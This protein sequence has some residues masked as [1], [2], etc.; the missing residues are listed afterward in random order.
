MLTY[1]DTVTSQDGWVYNYTNYFRYSIYIGRMIPADSRYD[2]KVHLPEYTSIPVPQYTSIPVFWFACIPVYTPEETA[3]V[4]TGGGEEPRPVFC[5]KLV[6]D[7]NKKK[8]EDKNIT[9]NFGTRVD[10]NSNF[11]QYEL[12]EV[13]P[14]MLWS[15]YHGFRGKLKNIYGLGE[16]K[17]FWTKKDKQ[18]DLRNIINKWLNF[19][20]LW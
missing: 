14:L 8:D 19:K 12:W 11:Y 20:I 1:M 13:Y 2:E 4:G 15:V 5:W 3:Q 9:H 18:V 16:S 17:C 7:N 10:I 6:W